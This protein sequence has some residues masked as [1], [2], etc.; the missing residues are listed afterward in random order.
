MS[1]MAENVI[2]A[3]AENR[4]SMLERIDVPPTPTTPASIRERTLADLIPKEKIR[5]ACDI[6]ATNII[7]QSLPP[8]VYTLVNHHTVSKE[9]WDI[10]KLLIEGSELSL[11]EQESKLYNEFDVFTSKKGE[12][13]HSCY[14]SKFVTDVKLAKDIHTTNFDQLYAYLR[15]HEV[16]ANEVRITRKIFL[17]PFAL[18]ANIYNSPPF[19]NNQPQYTPIVHRQSYQAPVFHQQPYQV[20]AVNQQSPA[21]FPQLDSGLVV[22]SFLPTND[23]IASLNKAMAFLST[24]FASR[25][26]PTKNQLR[27][28]SNPKNQATFQDG[29]I[30]VQNVQRRQT[31]SCTGTGAKGNATGIVV[32]QNMGN[33]TTNQSKVIRC[34]NYKGVGHIAK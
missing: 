9:I 8:D 16:H 24:S 17:D 14:L 31:Q 11:Q 33:V 7:L 19:Y 13:I 21:E 3:R 12:T 15:Q 32:I 25:Y 6:R 20:P 18:V 22:P 23:P 30:I 26:P 27:T 10:V 34:Y 1:T 5:E 28:L 2:A 29:E 4:P